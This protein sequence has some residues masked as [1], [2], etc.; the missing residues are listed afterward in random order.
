VKSQCRSPV[1]GHEKEPIDVEGFDECIE[2]SRV[3]EEAILD[4]RLSRLPKADQVGRNAAR[5]G[6]HLRHDVAPDE[7]RSRIAVQEER[8]G[9]AARSHFP[10]SHGR[11]ESGDVMLVDMRV[12]PCV[13]ANAR[14]VGPCPSDPWMH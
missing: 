2:V 4:I 13:L 14:V 8:D 7:R 5:H 3:I 12:H 6:R 10:V 11:I 1:L 9:P